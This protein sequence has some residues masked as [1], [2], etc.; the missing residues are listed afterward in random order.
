MTDHEQVVDRARERGISEILHFTTSTGLI[1]ILASGELLSRDQLKEADYV[2]NVTLLN[3]PNRSRDAAWTDY[4]NLSVTVV[5]SHMLG[6]SVGWH[7][8]DDI[9]WAVLA[10]DVEILGHD[11]VQFTTTN[12]V[13]PVCKRGEGLDAFEAMFDSLVPWGIYGSTVRRPTDKAANLTTH[14]QAE[15]LYPQ[16][17]PLE[18]PRTVYVKEPQHIDEVRAIL[19]GISSGSGVEL[20]NVVVA[21]KPEIFQTG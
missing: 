19:A 3:S 10:F 20:S 5:N 9:W 13:Y 12:N 4:A 18:H 2:H 15:V 1:G 11:G 6:S 17:L 16:R 7:E 14:F 8:N 21:C